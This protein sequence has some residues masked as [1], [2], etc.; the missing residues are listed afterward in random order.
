MS[1]TIGG[2]FV[3]PVKSCRGLAVDTALLT[4]RGLQHD[5]EWMI[6]AAGSE[7]GRFLTQRE[8]PRLA[9]VGT[10][11]PAAGLTLSAPRMEPF[12]VGD[13]PDGARRQVA[14]WRDTVRAIDQG[15]DVA[16]WL[17]AFLGVAV[18]L[19]RFDPEWR[20]ACNPQY[21]GD[22]GAHTGFADGYPVLILGSASLADLNARLQTRGAAPLPINR[23]RP[24][25]VVDGLESH[26]EDHLAT[27]GCGEVNLR[28]VKPCVRCQ[29]TT[30]DQDTAQ[31]GTEPLLTLGGYR[32]DP[33]LGGVT[34]GMNAI[35]AAGAG[36]M[37]ATGAVLDPG[38][39]F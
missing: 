28:L 21:A 15:D 34:F 39:N 38:W 32:N 12:T 14:V 35:V 1:P 11:L 33:A 18:R 8:H 30:T 19:V 6:V 3:Y 5:R 20:R 9:L 25:L 22:S 17:S 13:R 31:V 23:F 16:D 26:D 27:L 7:P 29:I 10:S 24:N 4:V 37:L 36:S 2:L